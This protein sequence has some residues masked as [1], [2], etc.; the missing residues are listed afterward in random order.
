MKIGIESYLAR[1]WLSNT[2]PLLAEL[3]VKCFRKA[4]H[5]WLQ[6][7]DLQP[8]EGRSPNYVAFDETVI[9]INSQ[10]SWLYTATDSDMNHLLHV[11]IVCDDNHCSDSYFLSELREKHNV[12]S[13]VFLVDSAKQ[14]QTSLRRAG[15][16]FHP[17]R[18]GNRNSIEPIFR[19][20]KRRTS[21]FSNCFSHVS[22]EPPKYGSKPSF[23]GIMRLAKH[24]NSPIHNFK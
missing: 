23:D 18:Y 14:L 2:V 8:T 3:G 10:Q 13:T 1:L 11:P 17:E 12:E 15:F 20:L 7:A 22:P 24:A 21:P 4:V 16:R 9:R 19:E 6:K 5:D